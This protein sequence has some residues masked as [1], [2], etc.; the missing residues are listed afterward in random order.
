MLA[1]FALSSALSASD[2]VYI[3]IPFAFCS[4]VPNSTLS[5][6]NLLPTVPVKSNVS[7]FTITENLTVPVV[8][9]FSL[10]AT[11]IFVT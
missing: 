8:S 3:L 6:S 1:N 7:L 4:A 2:F 5:T 10:S 9:A 11:L